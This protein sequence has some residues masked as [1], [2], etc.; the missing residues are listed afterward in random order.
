MAS[1]RDY[2]IGAATARKWL[3]VNESAYAGMVP[4][5]MVQAIAKAVIDAVDD[6]RKHVAQPPALSPQ[7]TNPASRSFEA[8]RPEYSRLWAK[9][10][11]TAPRAELDATARKLLDAKPR[12][13]AVEKTT[14]VP[15]VVIAVIHERESG[16]DFHCVLHNG[17]RI[18][19]TGRKTT[20]VPKGRGPFATWEAAAED[21]L[22]LDRLTKVK[23][24]SIEH[25]CYMLEL[26]NGFGYRAHHINSPYLWAGSSNYVHGKFVRDGVF[27]SSAVDRQL[28]C[29]PLIKT[30]MVFDATISFVV[31]AAPPVATVPAA[32]SAP[33]IAAAPAAPFWGATWKK[34]A[35]FL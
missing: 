15:W 29:M 11:V 18:I 3:N 1:Q 14:T 16:A 17:E 7:T 27:D 10:T 33:S 8:L 21:A 30:M 34:L 35:N 23:D 6:D 20:L 22:A 26:Y 4:E 12:Y 25:T 5:E 19:D 9:M 2:L 24:W 31:P 13:Q 32:T 28:G